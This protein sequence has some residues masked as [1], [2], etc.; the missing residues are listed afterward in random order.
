M[1]ATLDPTLRRLSLPGSGDVVLADTVGFIRRLPH[2]LVE[3]FKA[4]LDEVAEA[5]LL[6]HVI[7]ASS[8]HVERQ[9]AEVESVLREIGAD[10][11]PRIEVLNKIDLVEAGT[12]I[13]DT[14]QAD[15]VL[16]RVRISARS[17]A[18]MDVLRGAIAQALAQQQQN[19]RD[20]HLSA[21]DGRLRARLYA[22]G[23]VIEERIE[24]DGSQTLTV[25]VP[26]SMQQLLAAK[27][28]PLAAN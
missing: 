11:L 9:A 26:A 10:A 20:V 2:S 8:P 24:G 1:F 4:T 13:D 18:G 27:M 16:A 3:A 14:P 12:A 28:M 25:R 15:G 21:A 23:A 5:D 22:E 6:L 19:V 17:G 7:D